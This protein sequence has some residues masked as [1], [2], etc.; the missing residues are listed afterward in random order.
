MSE[1]FLSTLGAVSDVLSGA[2]QT[3][4][5]VVLFSTSESLSGVVPGFS[6]NAAH[7]AHAT[8]AE[9]A[10]ISSFWVIK[11]LNYFL[12]VSNLPV[13]HFGSSAICSQLILGAALCFSR[14]LLR[15]LIM[16]C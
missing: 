8:V 10:G 9:H 3:E 1:G 4:L 2:F 6:S 11:A 7:V 12:F 15:M 14:V 16:L 5:V 13:Y